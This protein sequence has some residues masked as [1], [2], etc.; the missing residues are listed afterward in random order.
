VGGGGNFDGFGYEG[1]DEE[2]ILR[3]VIEASK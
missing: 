3:M 1:M 2:E